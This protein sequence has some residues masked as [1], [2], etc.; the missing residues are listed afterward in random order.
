MFKVKKAFIDCSKLLQIIISNCFLLFFINSVYTAAIST[1]PADWT[2]LI[3]VQAKN[4]LS[5]FASKNLSDM[6]AVGSNTKL[7]ILVQWYQLNQKGIWRYKIHKNKIELDTYLPSDT[8]GN[9]SKDLIDAMKWS[10][11]KYPAQNYGLVL[12][13]HGVGIVDPVWGAIRGNINDFSPKMNIDAEMILDNPRA[14][15][16]DLT[17]SSTQE[18]VEIKEQLLADQETYI[19]RGIL[20]NEH[21]RTYMSNQQLVQALTEI[22][23]SVLCGKKINVLGMDACLMAMVEMAYQTRN[24][25]D[26]MIASQEVE[27]AYGWDYLTLMQSLSLGGITPIQ[28]AKSVVMSYENYYKNRIKFYTQS[29][30]LL[31]KMSLLKD[32]INAFVNKFKICKKNDNLAMK[33][34][35]KEARK[36]ALQFSTKN[37]IDLYSFYSRFYKTLEN[38]YALN[39]QKMLNNDILKTAVL[40][41]KEA[42]NLSMKLLEKTVIANVAGQNV[43]SAKGLS[44]YFPLSQIDPSYYRTE[45]TKDCLWI[46]FLKEYLSR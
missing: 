41:L 20:F 35:V 8:D 7:N 32:S 1:K 10:V 39:S 26:Y 16:T 28:F 38:N 14:Q 40:Q 24:Y 19:Q 6:S 46:D 22:K 23:N 27:L 31:D 17:Y 9:Q 34:A 4:N 2:V 37:Y 3:Y 33:N 25:A 29:A 43:I 15:I 30:I 42:I 36:S 13:N 44:I 45:F 11:S 18:E 5:K 21:S 12:W